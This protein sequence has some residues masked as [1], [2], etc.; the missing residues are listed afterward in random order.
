MENFNDA[1]DSIVE[2]GIVV[3]TAYG[4]ENNDACRR[5]PGS[6]PLA[7]HEGA[8]NSNDAR[9]VFSNCVKFWAPGCDVSGGAA[10]RSEQH[11]S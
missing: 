7:I 6:A 10:L 1:L 4:N 5:S 8:T 3:V 9:A 2:A 11:C